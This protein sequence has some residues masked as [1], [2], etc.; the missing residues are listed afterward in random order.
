MMALLWSLDIVPGTLARRAV[1]G[2][3]GL[4]PA[5][6]RLQEELLA[7]PSMAAPEEGLAGDTHT[8]ASFK[9]VALMV[10]GT[11]MQTYGQALT[12]E[13]EVLTAAADIL[14]DTFAAES[15]L[16]RALAIPQV[17]DQQRDQQLPG[18]TRCRR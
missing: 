9:K 8:V 16:L 13:Q 1:K 4:I 10:L 3:I 17:Q 11:A 12:D 6:K 14:I 18:Q 15:A 5:A 7:G 2:E